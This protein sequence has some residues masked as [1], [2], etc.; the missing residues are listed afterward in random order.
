MLR[1]LAKEPHTVYQLGS[2]K[3]EELV[4]KLLE[5]QGCE[6]TLTKQSR[7]G[8]YDIFGRIN[9][10][11]VPLVFLAECKRYAEKNRV[12]V[13]VIRGLYGV[14]EMQRANFGMVITTSSFTR[15]AR[16]EKLRIGHRMDLKEFNDLKDWFQ[17]YKSEG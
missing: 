3:F 16:E 6:V 4:A 1:D 2:R 10:G 14:T 11:P 17:K 5:D 7:D 15:D 8:G 13:E 9:S 12:G